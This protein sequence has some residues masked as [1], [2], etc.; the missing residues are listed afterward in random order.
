MINVFNIEKFATH[1]GP[2]IRTA[3][4][5]KGCHLHCP[6]CANPE[7]WAI[8]PTF[9]YDQRKC[10]GCLSCVNQCEHH[11]LRFENGI[12]HD[13]QVCVGCRKCEDVCL[14]EAIHFAG[15]QSTIDDVLKEILK[16]KDYFDES[17]GGVTISGGEPFLQFD[18]FLKLVK[19]CKAKGLHVAVETTGSYSQEWVKEAFDYIDLF[20]LDLKHIDA[21]KLKKVT[22][23]NL[24]QVLDNIAYITSKDV[25]K[26]IIRVPV[27]PYFNYDEKTL[28]QILNTAKAYHI[29]EVNLLPYH[30]LGKNKWDQMHQTY[31]LGNEKMLDKKALQ[32][33]V[34]Y[35]ETIGVKVKLGG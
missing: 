22:G 31:Q 27:I 9:M 24:Q 32:A 12:L 34:E 1:D 8:T 15:K 28:H 18:A 16:D 2:G 17:N 33:Y 13:S 29:Q 23:G 21:D 4:F 19:A 35:G 6:W 11:A 10:V 20:L 30:T 14:K 25:S 5:L 3:V 7:S 26:I